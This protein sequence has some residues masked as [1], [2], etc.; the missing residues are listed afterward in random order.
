VRTDTQSLQREPWLDPSR[1]AGWWT[2]PPNHESGI[3]APRPFRSEADQ[4]S[5]LLGPRTIEALPGIQTHNV[6]AL[7]CA[8]PQMSRSKPCLM[9][10][11]CKGQ[12]THTHDYHHRASD[13]LDCLPVAQAFSDLL[14]LDV[15]VG[16]LGEAVQP[17]RNTGALSSI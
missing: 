9:G 10:S 2:S 7:S 6:L 17:D 1:C 3:M 14:G 4:P 13:V 12:G 11:H 15:D 5:P 8:V 16:F